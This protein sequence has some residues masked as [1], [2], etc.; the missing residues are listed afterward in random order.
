MK[1]QNAPFAVFCPDGFAPKLTLCSMLSEG[2]GQ[3][4]ALIGEGSK[5]DT[6]ALVTGTIRA[7][8]GAG[9]TAADLAA[10]L[11]IAVKDALKDGEDVQI[12]G[13]LLGGDMFDML[14]EEDDD[15]D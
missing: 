5:V 3:R 7:A 8:L 2:K 9:I 4:S 14:V 11:V 10:C 1:N 12:K 6:L 13:G 15:E